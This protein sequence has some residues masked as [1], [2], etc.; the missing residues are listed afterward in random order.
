MRTA[1]QWHG[2]G[3][4]GEAMASGM[5]REVMLD[6]LIFFL[7]GIVP[8]PERSHWPS[9]H[10]FPSGRNSSTLPTAGKIGCDSETETVS[11]GKRITFSAR[12]DR[13][14]SSRRDEQ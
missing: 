12:P 1:D 5:L 14:Q 4:R 13:Q 11:S 7:S 2:Y 3:D 9:M 6:F 8:Q 10:E